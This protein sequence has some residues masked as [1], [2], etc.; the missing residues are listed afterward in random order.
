[1]NYT[2]KRP[3]GEFENILDNEICKVKKII[4]SPNQSPSYQYHFKREEYWII[5]QGYGKL[6]KDGNFT[7]VSK[8]SIIHVPV[9]CKHQITNLGNEDL[10]FIEIQLGDYFG[11]DDIVRIEDNYGRL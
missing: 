9:E 1:M 4:I 6:K 3:W 7:E 2:E 11:E 5:V 10:I 8:G